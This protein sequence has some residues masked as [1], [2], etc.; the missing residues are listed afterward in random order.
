[1]TR[2]VVGRSTLALPCV[3]AS[4]LAGVVACSPPAPKPLPGGPPPEYEVPRGYTGPGLGEAA[5]SPPASPPSGNDDGPPP[6]AAPTNAAQP[7]P[8]AA[9]P[10]APAPAPP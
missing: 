5:P 3:V 10:V 9:K 8:E 1:M 2:P 7:P 4:M 6:A